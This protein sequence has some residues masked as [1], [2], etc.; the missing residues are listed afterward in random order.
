MSNSDA[1]DFDIS[2]VTEG[3]YYCIINES[4]YSKNREIMMY[5][6]IS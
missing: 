1:Y 5:I 2:I 3:D 4:D 6:Y